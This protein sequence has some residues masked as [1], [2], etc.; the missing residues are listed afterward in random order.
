MKRQRLVLREQAWDT[1][2][3]LQSIP[4]YDPLRD[5]HCD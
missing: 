1:R 4:R 5:I 3:H 2:F